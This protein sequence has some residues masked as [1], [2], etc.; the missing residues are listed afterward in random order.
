MRF[1]GCNPD[2]RGKKKPPDRAAVL[3][4]KYNLKLSGQKIIRSF[5]K[6][7]SSVQSVINYLA[8]RRCIRI[9]VHA[10]TRPQV[11]DDT[12]GCDLHGVTGQ[13]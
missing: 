6:D 12:L 7:A 3:L 4:Q 8:N 13:L 10:G 5:G 1:T 9:N 11:P 2:D